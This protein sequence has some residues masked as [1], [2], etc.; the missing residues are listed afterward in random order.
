M[1]WQGKSTTRSWRN[2]F[3][4]GFAARIGERL[5]EATAGARDTH[6]HETAQDFL[7]VLVRRSEAVDEALKEAFPSLG[8]VRTSVSNIDGL[9]AG[10]RFA[11]RAELDSDRH[12]GR[13]V[14]PLPSLG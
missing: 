10:N 8:T 12:L 5:A 4:Y 7:P 2:A 3:W 14:R 11:N 9:D 1:D 13:Q 6:Q